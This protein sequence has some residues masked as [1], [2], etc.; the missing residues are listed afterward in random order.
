M[1]LKTSQYL[2]N[3]QP[4]DII[5]MSCPKCKDTYASV[6][7]SSHKGI[8]QGKETVMPLCPTCSTHFVVKGSGKSATDKLVHTCHTCGSTKVACCVM[9]KDGA[10]TPG[11]GEKK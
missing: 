6:V 2:Q 9:K 5:I 4:G 8:P 3:L 1:P 7:D 11:M 10:A